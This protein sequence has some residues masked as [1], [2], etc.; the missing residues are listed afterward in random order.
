MKLFGPF[1]LLAALLG[2]VLP[3][4]GETYRWVDPASGRVVISDQPP[5]VGVKPQ[6]LR[7]SAGSGGD[8]LPL[9]LREPVERFPVR[10]YTTPACTTPCAEARLLLQARGI[11]HTEKSAESPELVAELKSLAGEAT[12]PTL[13]VGRQAA[14][15]FQ[16][17]AWNSLLDLAG[18]P[19]RPVPGY[20]P[21]PPP[22]AKPAAAPEPAAAAQ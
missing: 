3:A 2:V 9:A 22:P 15:G 10:L 14:R 8:E 16:L 13:L 11:P 7:R 1:C 12:V 5:P 17:S 6:Q 4:T 18:Y 21:P 19:Q 20:R